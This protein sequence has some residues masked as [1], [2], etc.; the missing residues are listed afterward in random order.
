METT[1]AE[2]LAIEFDSGWMHVFYQTNNESKNITCG[3]KLS[4]KS[5]I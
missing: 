1:C 3:C 4:G 5:D 2:I